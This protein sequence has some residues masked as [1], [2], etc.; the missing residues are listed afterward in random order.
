M[1]PRA[2]R[3]RRSGSGCGSTARTPLRSGFYILHSIFTRGA[4]V[5]SSSKTWRDAPRSVNGERGHTDEPGGRARHEPGVRKL[6]GRH[7]RFLHPVTRIP[8]TVLARIFYFNA[9]P[10]RRLP[11][12]PPQNVRLTVPRQSRPGT[13][14]L[15]NSIFSRGRAGVEPG[16]GSWCATAQSCTHAAHGAQHGATR[17]SCDA[18][19][20]TPCAAGPRRDRIACS[21]CSSIDD[22]LRLSS[23][24]WPFPCAPRARAL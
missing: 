3:G 16:R 8:I 7:V 18:L 22:G 17:L 6:T 4:P 21:P 20:H 12:P 13:S 11:P 10:G 14:F 1:A 5:G 24:C 2:V 15:L 19:P 23:M 9:A